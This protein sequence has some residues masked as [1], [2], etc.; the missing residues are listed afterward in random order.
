MQ[1][2]TTT[3]RIKLSEEMEGLT[4]EQLRDQLPD[5]IQLDIVDCG[6]EAVELDWESLKVEV[7]S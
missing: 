2:L 7:Q 6:V 4:L 3:M 5:C 1:Q